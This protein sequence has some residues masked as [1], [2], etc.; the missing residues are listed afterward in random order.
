MEDFAPLTHARRALSRFLRATIRSALGVRTHSEQI[1]GIA[2]SWAEAGPHD[3]EPV[4]LLHGFAGSKDNWLYFATLL[5]KRYRVI[6]PDLPG[7]GDSGR[8]P[9]ATYDIEAQVDRLEHFLAAIGIER[10]HLGGNSMGGFVALSFALKHPDRLCSLIL[11][12]NAGVNGPRLS[13]PQQAMLQGE[14]PLRIRSEADVD[15]IL[16]FI[17]SRP[18]RLPWFAKRYLAAQFIE[19]EDLLQSI[20]DQILADAL[21]RPLDDRLA[22]VRIPTQIIW[23][24]KDGLLDASAAEVQHQRIPRSE[25]TIIEDAGHVPM[26][27]RPH[28]TAKISLDFLS[29]HSCAAAVPG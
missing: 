1:D 16:G 19:R 10:C 22:D 3:A 6:C 2:W 8:S 25:L 20:F 7:F 11:L 14:N 5:A 23:G 28:L 13:A 24:G 9:T 27:E 12:N 17:F 21:E 18:P 26:I 29:R 15:A 4:I